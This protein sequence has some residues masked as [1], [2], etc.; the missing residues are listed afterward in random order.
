M[1]YFIYTFEVFSN[2]DFVAGGKFGRTTLLNN[3]KN[4]SSLKELIG[5]NEYYARVF[6][7]KENL[8]IRVTGSKKVSRKEYERESVDFIEI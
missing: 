1:H 4:L 3:P 7:T 8:N 6:K 2:F 5:L